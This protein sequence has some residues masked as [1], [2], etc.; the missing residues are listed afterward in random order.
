MTSCG[1]VVGMTEINEVCVWCTP[2]AL[3]RAFR[4]G[5]PR[6]GPGHVGVRFDDQ[7]LVEVSLDDVDVTDVACE[8]IAGDPGCV[9]MRLWND[10]HTSSIDES[11]LHFP[12]VVRRGLVR[13]YWVG[14]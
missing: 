14:A 13:I 10:L 12:I 2:S 8:A 4:D 6:H 7:N 11:E 1:K 5:T 3:P 9:L